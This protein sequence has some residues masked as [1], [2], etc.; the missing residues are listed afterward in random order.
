VADDRYPEARWTTDDS[1][2]NCRTCGV[3]IYPH[4]SEDPITQGGLRYRN[5][6]CEKG[7]LDRTKINSRGQNPPEASL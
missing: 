7:H 6:E 2:I 1:S 5:W 4:K 3:R